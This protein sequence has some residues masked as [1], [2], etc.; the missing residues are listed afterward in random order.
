MSL[1]SNRLSVNEVAVVT[2]VPPRAVND[3]VDD[4]ILPSRFVVRG[5]GRALRPRACYLDAVYWDTSEQLTKP[6][7]LRIVRQLSEQFGQEPAASDM[8]TPRWRLPNLSSYVLHDGV[9]TIDLRSI[10]RR[11]EKGGDRLDEAGEMVVVDPEVLGGIPVIRRTRIPVHDVAASVRE[12]I[13]VERI[14]RAYP[15]LTPRK[16]ELA[17]LWSDAHPP[18]G[19]PRRVADD[20]PT[21]KLRSEVRVVRK[22]G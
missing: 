3:I 1:P 21:A 9:L 18:T 5:P 16:I 12:D 13:P 19:K 11:V 6:E 14:L 7:R 22:A 4:A 8:A 20:I 10:L 15:V 2:N 17:K